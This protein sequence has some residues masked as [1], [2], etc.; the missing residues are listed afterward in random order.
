MNT[1]LVKLMKIAKNN[2]M[3]LEIR[4][5]PDQFD[6]IVL[7][8]REIPEWGDSISNLKA[9]DFMIDPSNEYRAS[10]ELTDEIIIEK[11]KEMIEKVKAEKEVDFFMEINSK[12]IKRNKE[13]KE[14]GT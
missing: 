9:C 13:E 14:N 4:F 12:Y 7:H 1:L 3:E 5:M 2:H 6:K 11:F 8:V 10:I